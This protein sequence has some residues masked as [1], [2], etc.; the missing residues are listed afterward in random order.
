MNIGIKIFIFCYIVC[1]TAPQSLVVWG[2]VE[3]GIFTNIVL[4]S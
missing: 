1:E 4:S 2:G 3:V